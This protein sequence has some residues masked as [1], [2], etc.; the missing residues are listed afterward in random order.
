MN[1]MDEPTS[2]GARPLSHV[3]WLVEAAAVGILLFW[4]VYL[5][6][7]WSDL[8]DEVPMRF[9]LDGQPGSLGPRTDLW[10]LPG[11]GIIL[12]GALTLVSRLKQFHNLP[13][14]VTP[15][16]AAEL[17]TFSR[18]F[19][20]VVKLEV[21]CLFGYIEWKILQTA[22]GNADGLGSWFMALVVGAVLLTS[23]FP[24][25]RLRRYRGN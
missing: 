19:I 15:E 18:R 2:K 20:N 3:E 1:P 4:I 8:P 7:H 24:V 13:V 11:M 6:S 21:I 12:Y 16:N 23:L 5:P 17:Y 22:R 9:G 25:F 14:E 10:F